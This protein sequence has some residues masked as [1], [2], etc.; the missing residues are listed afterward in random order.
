[1]KPFRGTL[2]PTLYV[3]LLSIRSVSTA[4]R[5][6]QLMF[7]HHLAYF[8]LAT[9]FFIAPQIQVTYTPPLGVRCPGQDRIIRAG[10]SSAKLTG[11]IT[12]FC[13]YVEVLLRPLRCCSF[14]RCYSD[15]TGLL[16]AEFS[17]G[18]A[19]P[20]LSLCVRAPPASSRAH[21]SEGKA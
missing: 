8:P 7:L 1:M 21:T 3:S 17:I 5:L 13:L 2:T 6:T 9:G 4:S 18:T 15:N 12:S 10:V 16:P 11:L 14:P 19:Q 20:P